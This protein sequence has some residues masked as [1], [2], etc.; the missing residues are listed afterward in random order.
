MTKGQAPAPGMQS[1]GTAPYSANRS[2]RSNEV[3]SFVACVGSQLEAFQSRAQDTVFPPWVY[4]APVSHQGFSL[5]RGSVAAV[6][7]GLLTRAM[8]GGRR[9]GSGNDD[10]VVAR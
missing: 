2:E 5:G 1:A 10:P 8:L 3:H 7:G 9:F 6:E 4:L